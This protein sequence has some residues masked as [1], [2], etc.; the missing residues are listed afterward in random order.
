[1]KKILIITILSLLINI[2]PLKVYSCIDSNAKI[3]MI[4]DELRQC[5]ATPLVCTSRDSFVFS[6]KRIDGWLP[7]NKMNWEGS[8]NDYCDNKGYRMVNEEEMY[9]KHFTSGFVITALMFLTI[10]L[11]FPLFLLLEI[12]KSKKT[13]NINQS[14]KKYKFFFVPFVYSFFSLIILENTSTKYSYIPIILIFILLLM[15]VWL[16]INVI[17]GIMR[18]DKLIHEYF[19][20]F[21]LGLFLGGYIGMFAIR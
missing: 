6:Y 17:F 18:K 12:K 9:K 13:T 16:L 2:L 3:A 4:N 8:F 1:M 15:L 21:M 10:F 11:I 7:I 20:K 5:G 19:L 14:I